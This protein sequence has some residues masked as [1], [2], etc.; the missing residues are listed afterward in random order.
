MDMDEWF[1]N[2]EQPSNLSSFVIFLPSLFFACIQLN[3]RAVNS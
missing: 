1:F 3:S 2:Y